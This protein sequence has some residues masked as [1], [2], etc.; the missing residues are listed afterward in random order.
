MSAILNKPGKEKE[1]EATL[2]SK[3][4]DLLNIEVP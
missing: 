1:K 4:T 3:L 2:N